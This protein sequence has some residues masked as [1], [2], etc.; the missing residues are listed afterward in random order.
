ME[1]CRKPAPIAGVLRMLG[2][3]LI[4]RVKDADLRGDL[5]VAVRALLAYGYTLD[6]SRTIA[7]PAIGFVADT[8]ATDAEA[9]VNLLSQVLTDE[10]FERFGP[11]EL[12][13][14]AR[15]IGIVAQAAPDFAIA[16]YHDAYSREVSANRKTSMGSGRIL[17]LTSNARQD[18]EFARWSLGEHF[19]KFL[20]EFPVEATKAFLVAMAGYVA[21]R[22]PIPEELG[23]RVVEGPAGDVRL[24]QD[25]SYIWAHEPHSQYAQ[26]G[27]ALLSRFEVFLETGEERAA[28]AAAEY[29]ARHATLA[30]VWSRLF[31]AAAARSGPLRGLLAPYAMQMEFVIEPDTR[32]DAIDLVA[33][34]YDQLSEPERRE[35][36]TKAL[37]LSLDDFKHP[38][39]AKRGLLTSLFGKIGGDRLAT[40]EARSALAEAPTT[41]D[42]NRRLFQITTGWI[43]P[44]TYPWLDEETRAEP[45]VGEMIDALDA[46]TDT[47]H[48]KLNDKGQIADLDGA[49]AALTALRVQVDAEAVSDETL[50]Q[51]ADGEFA[52]GV[53]QLVRSDLIGAETPAETLTT[54]VGWIEFA[55]RSTNPET[56]GE[57]EAKFESFQSW[58]SPSARL[59]GAEAVLDLCLKRPEVYP[60]SQPLIDRMLIDPHPAVRMSAAE[61]LVRIWDIDRQGFWERAARI[62]AEEQNR[63]VLDCF[64]SQT[65]GRLVWHGA[66]R[67]VADRPLTRAGCAN[68]SIRRRFALRCRRSSCRAIHPARGWRR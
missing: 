48:L 61:H 3:L 9:S 59:E 28:L 10:R 11:E 14:L 54:I 16:V 44:A 34:H 47:L 5:G 19:P 27:E 68:C 37:Q 50:R 17:N 35:F 63:G 7:T 42:V 12:P 24:Q 66:A 21:R 4:D 20:A 67:E 64:V 41:G 1:L 56:D 38:V 55:C 25:R 49:M 33:A 30:V 2:F 45:A 32:K 51:R 39:E 52:Q 36:E 29:A 62:V 57:T 22:H 40:E 18:F 46:V 15:K 26:D 6:D 43:D 60:A 65:L 31:M 53:H 23:V 58:G 13:V 8:V